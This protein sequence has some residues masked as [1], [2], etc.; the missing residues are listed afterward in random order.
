MGK[1]A[2]SLIFKACVLEFARTK[3]YKLSWCV[4][5]IPYSCRTNLKLLFS[6]PSLCE[7]H[8]N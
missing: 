6:Y 3:L 2:K 5:H 8:F 1:M 7:K 4:Q